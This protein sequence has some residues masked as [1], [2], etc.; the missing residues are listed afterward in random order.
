VSASRIRVAPRA[1]R[2]FAAG[3][4]L[5]LTGFHPGH[6]SQIEERIQPAASLFE[7][8][9]PP[10]ALVEFP[11]ASL[12]PGE[13]YASLQRVTLLPEAEV[14]ESPIDGPRLV[15]VSSGRV[16]LR[17][18][19]SG[20]LVYDN[21]RS[22]TEPVAVPS[23]VT[24]SLAS[25]QTAMNPANV[26]V[27]LSNAEQAEV[28]WIQIQLE[29]PPTVCPCHAGLFGVRRTP[30]A[31]ETIPAALPP[32]TILV[33]ARDRLDPGE[34]LPRPVGVAFWMTGSVED[35]LERHG[36]GSVVNRTSEPIEIVVLAGI[37][38]GTP[39]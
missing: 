30:L 14:A 22:D 10:H 21:R 12:P 20:V 11:A 39:S 23:R 24:R 8:G 25:G 9:G 18:E 37:V 35:A 31:N 1:L 19:L 32:G 27:L 7:A 28:E 36:D 29:T 26:P 4:L 3:A 2:T 34:V 5:L 17:P 13:T 6:A 15:S 33:L 16:N 38:D